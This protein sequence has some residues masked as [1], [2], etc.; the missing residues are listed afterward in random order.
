MIQDAVFIYPE[1]SGSHNNYTYE[2]IQLGVDGDGN[3][4]TINGTNLSH[5]DVTNG[6]ELHWTN[7]KPYVIY[8]YAKIPENETLVIDPG[9]RVHFH[10]NSGLIVSEKC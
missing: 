9:A 4:V 1:R 10:A 2:Q 3:P 8:G 5:I 7:A 6:D